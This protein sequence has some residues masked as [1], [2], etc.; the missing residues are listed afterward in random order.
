VPSPR[1]SGKVCAQCGKDVAG[2]VGEHRHGE[3]VCSACQADP[4]RIVQHLLELSLRGDPDLVAIQGYAVL[5]EL[6]R[7]GMGAVYLARHARTG[8]QVALKVMLPRV[9]ADPH[10]KELF[11]RE[12]E[13]T[14]ALQHPNVVRVRDAG[15]SHGTFF[16]TLEYCDGGSVDQL[17]KRQGGPLPVAEAAPIIVQ[18]LD[19]LEYAHNVFGPGKG[20]VHRDLKPHNLFLAGS[21]PGRVA[22]VGDYGLAKA[23]D[24]AGLS[25]LTCSGA[26]MGTPVFM[27]RQQVINFKYARPEVDVWAMAASFYFLLTGR[28]VRD[29]PEGM[30]WW[31]AVLHNDAVPI[32]QRNPAV[33]QRLADVID[34][35]LVEAPSLP[36]KSAAAF[37]QALADALL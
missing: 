6:G 17:L 29:F 31:L 27:P 30:E 37:K 13:S 32:R 12:V 9:A 33:P 2:E 19:G 4:A 22:K 8:E 20:L 11:L 24:L 10:A 34:A 7:G 14:R 3:F 35:A 16:L 5:K 28:Y 23:F 25:G 18:A 15:C 21:G 26:M 1:R 36:F